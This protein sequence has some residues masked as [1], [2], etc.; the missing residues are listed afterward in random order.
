MNTRVSK[1]ASLGNCSQT[2]AQT[3][4]SLTQ[5]DPN[6]SLLN[7]SLKWWGPSRTDGVTRG[8]AASVI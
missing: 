7:F 2:R 5:T 3:P 8:V 6:L 1:Q 4:F